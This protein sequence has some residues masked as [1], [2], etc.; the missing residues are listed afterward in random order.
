MRIIP[1]LLAFTAAFTLQAWNIQ[2]TE[3]NNPA[4][5]TAAKEL[6]HY[7]N[8]CSNDV[9]INGKS[10]VFHIG[11]TAKARTL[12]IDTAKLAE[13]EWIIKSDKNDVVI[14]GGGTRGTLYG[15]F[16]FI[17][18]YLGVRYFSA[19]EEY[20]PA[21]KTF[22]I[23]SLNDKGKPFF[24]MRN[25]FR[26]PKFHKDKGRFAAKMRIN[27]DGQTPISAEYGGDYAYGLPAHVHS[28]ERADGYLPTSKYFKTHPE[29]YALIDG[30]RNGSAG[31]G[32]ICFSNP[33]LI[34]LFKSKLREYV[35]RSEE[36]AAKAGV[37]MPKIYDISINDNVYFCQCKDC[38]EAVKKYN[39][40]GV[41][42]RFLNPIAEDLKSYRPKC[43]VQTLAYFSTIDAPK[44]TVA[45]DNIIIRFC[46]TYSTL[47]EDIKSPVNK[48]FHDIII[49]WSKVCKNLVIWDYAITYDDSAGMPYTSEFDYDTNFKFYADNNVK[50]VFMEH[51]NPENADIY[52]LKVY[53][54]AKY[55]ENPY[56]NFN[57]VYNDFM[58]KY[59]GSAAG[60]IKEYRLRLEKA[61]NENKAP[62]AYFAPDTTGFIYIDLDTV[63]DCRRILAEAEDKVKNAPVLLHRVQRAA[64]GTDLALGYWLT[65]SY[66]I[67]A[68]LDGKN[69]AEIQRLAAESR[70]R[71]LNTY[72]K[73]IANLNTKIGSG[74]INMLRLVTLNNAIKKAKFITPDI[75]KDKEHVIVDPIAWQR[76]TGSAIP[77]EDVNAY[78]GFVYSISADQNG[79]L[80]KND[81]EISLLDEKT[82][83]MTHLTSIKLDKLNNSYQWYKLGDFKFD[84]DSC[85]CFGKKRFMRFRPDILAKKYRNKE[86]EIY[87]EMKFAGPYYKLAG[88][89]NA[90]KL[91][92]IAIVFKP[93]SFWQKLKDLFD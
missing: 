85:I 2:E 46:D 8:L 52:D 9:K 69:T 72:N 21:K 58:D 22:D 26:D 4:A 74:P 42:L 39:R 11:N 1:A 56:L 24:L 62:M 43:F 60:K 80:L 67:Q 86:V 32:Q 44:D 77:E 28:I 75:F 82:D 27:Q 81:I 41:L 33:D 19:Y 16:I 79:K 65:F 40:S 61:A 15:V 73:T 84:G 7:I 23:N 89:E 17:E 78:Y 25:V 66:M 48:N 90:V 29:Y 83:K 10:A 6:K 34:P 87:A 14:T 18:K 92:S 12:G 59:Y 31:R 47:T 53:L 45:A 68:K 35:R 88:K 76:H 3:K 91:G 30:K 20:I 36:R 55:L 70:T 64:F 50:G 51:E 13:E 49:K 37:E 54:E 38:N 5:E 71:M 63:L 93:R 57:K